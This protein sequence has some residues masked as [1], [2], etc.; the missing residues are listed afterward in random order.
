MTTSNPEVDVEDVDEPRDMYDSVVDLLS[1]VDDEFHPPLSERDKAEENGGGVEG[2]VEATLDQHLLLAS[3][4]GRETGLMLYRR[5]DVPGVD[6]GSVY[7]ETIAVKPGYQGTGVGRQMYD[8]LF[9]LYPAS[10]IST[11]TWESNN[12]HLGLLESFGF[13]EV[14]RIPDDRRGGVDTVYL[15]LEPESR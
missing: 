8:K 9:D 13:R 7:V 10:S 12:S 14:H 2:Y 3:V 11:K 1:S 4:E 6:D 15:C 5:E